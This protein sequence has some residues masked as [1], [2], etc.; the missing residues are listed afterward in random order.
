MADYDIEF[1]RTNPADE[2]GRFTIPNGPNHVRDNVNGTISGSWATALAGDTLSG[3]DL[4]IIVFNYGSDPICVAMSDDADPGA[5]H[6]VAS[7]T[8]RELRLNPAV[9]LQVKTL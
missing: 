1:K 7:G 3:T 2:T 6:V 9:D 8:Q 4:A 5:Y